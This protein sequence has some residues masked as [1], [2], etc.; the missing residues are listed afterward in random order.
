MTPARK[1][2]AVRLLFIGDIVG[3]PGRDGLARV[4]PRWIDERRPDLVVA[5]LENSAGG[6]GVTSKAM[7]E[8]AP[9]PIDLFTSGNHVW[10]KND[11]FRFLTEDGRVLRPFNFPRR[12]PGRGWAV[13]ETAG[14]IKIGVINLCGR[15]YMDPNLVAASPFDA[16]EEALALTGA[17]T[18]IAL[19]DFHAEATSE[20]QA[21]GWYLN[22]RVSAVIGTHTHVQTADERILPGGTAF[23][24]DAG[25][26]GPEDS[27]IGM[28]KKAV[29]EKF[30]TGM[31]RRFEVARGGPVRVSAVIVG[32]NAANG[33]AMNIERLQEV[34]TP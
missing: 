29:I 19:V 17:E 23:I 21:L 26:T 24:T 10:H 33:R 6:F 15:S 28:A 31:P 4:L 30:L 27:V 18:P 2:R 22:G 34:T 12:T 1:P 20:K 11:G 25:M 32:I 14:G 5:N 7:R 3:K 8:L 13:V 9:L 16:V